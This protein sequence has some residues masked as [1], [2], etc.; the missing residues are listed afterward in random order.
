MADTPR[1]YFKELRLQQFRSLVALANWKTFSAA[2]ASLR[3]TRASVWQQVR[4]LE[5]ELSCTLLRT[6][7]QRVEFTPAGLRLVEIAAPLVAGFDSA[8]TALFA[9][10][11]G[12]LPQ[13]LVIAASPTFLV[14]ALRD[15]ISR[16]RSSHPK[17]HLTIMERNSAVAIELLEQGGADL[18]VAARPAHVREHPTLEYTALEA[19]PFTLICRPD[20]PLLARRVI[21][22]ADILKRPLIL[23][24][25]STYCRAQF[26][27]VVSQAGLRD[28][29][30]IVIESN[31]PAMLFEYVRLGLGV[32]LTPLPAKIATSSSV[33]QAGIGL[34][35]VASIFGDE[36]IYYVRRKGDFETPYAAL[37]RKM[38]L[39]QV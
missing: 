1:H 24:G 8:K 9:A 5:R 29:A 30:N 35:S 3:I 6:R 36:P 11:D 38:V 10:I 26:D 12:E 22:L 27:S 14:H 16:I 32:A 20:D 19:Y 17:L 21:K 33:L 7:A 18:A 37:F 25:G 2:A 13:T 23:S 15:P 4:S 28:K 31:F 39:E 34:R